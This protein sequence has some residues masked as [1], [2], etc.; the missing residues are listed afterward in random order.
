[1][2]T[3]ASMVI[4]GEILAIFAFCFG[5]SL[6]IAFVFLKLVV[7][8]TTRAS[9]SEFKPMGVA[10]RRSLAALCLRSHHGSGR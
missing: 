6:G 1:M 8:L 3:L 9:G 4:T 10:S 5:T 2:K 7:T